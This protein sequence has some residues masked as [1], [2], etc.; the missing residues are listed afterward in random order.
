MDEDNTIHHHISIRVPSTIRKRKKDYNHV[1][2]SITKKLYKLKNEQKVKQLNPKIIGYFGRCF[3]CCLKQNEGDKLSI[4]NGL[5]SIVSHSFGDHS[6]CSEWC[7]YKRDP[8]LF[9]F[10]SFP[11]G[12]PLTDPRL[13]EELS[14]IFA[15]YTKSDIL[16]RLACF[17][18]TQA[19]ERFNQLVSTKS[20]KAGNYSGSPSNERFNQLVSTKSP[21]AGNYSGSASL[22]FRVAASVNQKN[23]GYGYPENVSVRLGITAKGVLQKYVQVR[24]LKTKTDKQR[25]QTKSFR[26]RSAAKRLSSLMRKDQKC[27]KEGTTYER[28]VGLKTL[29]ETVRDNSMDSYSFSEED[30]RAS[31]PSFTRTEIEE[32]IAFVTLSKTRPTLYGEL[33]NTSEPTSKIIFD[34][35]TSE[36]S[37]DPCEVCQI[38]A[39]VSSGHSLKKFNCYVLL[40]GTISHQ[41]S[42]VHG[43]QITFSEG[44]RS[45]AKNG[46]V[47]NSV[48]IYKA[49][50]EFLAFIKREVD[51]SD[52]CPV[53]LIAHNGGKMT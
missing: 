52:N 44:K 23:E 8:G 9:L 1:K 22:S 35:E 20:P 18:S 26:K 46:E 13:K 53:L 27:R 29:T 32:V 7:R 24:N 4:K 15:E 47:V 16:E 40:E 33:E 19:N 31:Q 17:S 25:K 3:G 49:V 50:E 21:K 51:A 39:V 48:T 30:I 14:K 10:R 38:S 6:K 28:N 37:P 36:L 2:K 45:L 11:S 42:Q 41:A 12:N 5:L 43:L 34:F